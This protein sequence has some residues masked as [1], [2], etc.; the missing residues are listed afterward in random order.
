[1]RAGIYCLGPAP[2]SPAEWVAPGIPETA[3]YLYHGIYL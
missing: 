2:G 3:S 1:M